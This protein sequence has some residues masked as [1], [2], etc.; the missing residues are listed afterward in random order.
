MTTLT[1]PRPR[2]VRRGAVLPPLPRL[3]GVRGNEIV[4]EGTWKGGR[5]SSPP[6]R[7]ELEK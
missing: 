7:I 6:V 2:A 1:T 5:L 4:N 3:R